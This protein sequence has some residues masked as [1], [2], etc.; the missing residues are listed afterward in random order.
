MLF[1]SKEFPSNNNEVNQLKYISTYKMGQI[2]ITKLI[3]EPFKSSLNN[4]N[5]QTSKN[6]QINQVLSNTN[7]NNSNTNN[8][9]TNT[10]S[11]TYKAI[12]NISNKKIHK[13]NLSASHNVIHIQ[14]SSNF[15]CSKKRINKPNQGTNI[16]NNKNDKKQKY[17]AVKLNRNQFSKTTNNLGLYIHNNFYNKSSNKNSFSKNKIKSK[18]NSKIQSES[19]HSNYILSSRTPSS[20]KR[21]QKK[22]AI[23][24]FMGKDNNETNINTFKKDNIFDLYIKKSKNQSCIDII[25]NFKK[26]KE[27][28]KFDSKYQMT[29]FN[30]YLKVR[31]S[32]I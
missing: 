28:N 8:T 18:S 16:M 12:E 2:G 26:R 7:T 11:N 6:I 1:Q 17:E 27:E 15:N 5:N 24:D 10:N 32:R 14:S 21:N 4:D 19:G 3:E 25:Q 13:S 29:E 22:Y 20:I 9:N 31:K 23:S 30:T